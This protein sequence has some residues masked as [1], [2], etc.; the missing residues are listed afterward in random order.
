MLDEHGDI[1]FPADIVAEIVSA[2]MRQAFE[3]RI[4]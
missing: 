1:L 4:K 3:F 2:A